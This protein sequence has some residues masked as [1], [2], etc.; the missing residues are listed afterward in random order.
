MGLL[1]EGVWQD[2]WYDTK[3]SGGTFQRQASQFR[4]W[5]TKEGAPGPSGSGG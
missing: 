2:R 1:V 4:H 3:A 5:V